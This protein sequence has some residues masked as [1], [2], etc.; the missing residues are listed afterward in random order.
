MTKC[1]ILRAG[2]LLLGLVTAWASLQNPA[3]DSSTGTVFLSAR[4]NF[5]VRF[6]P[7]PNPIP[8]NQPFA[9]EIWILDK[10]GHPPEA[11]ALVIDARM[12]EH[13]HGM[14]REPH[15]TTL[16]PG[17]FKVTNMLFHMP[18]RWVLHFDMTHGGLTERGS[19][20]VKL[21]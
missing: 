20:E 18:G 2:F 12:P 15:I 13:R 10:D 5:Q 14:V 4:K 8:R 11:L 19:F 16:G 17:H 21:E 3:G 6:Q 7:D 9:L 1:R